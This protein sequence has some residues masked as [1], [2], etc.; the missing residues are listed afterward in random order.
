M[1]K[2]LPPPRCRLGI[3]PGLEL[4][5]GLG[6]G[7]ALG[8]G[9]GLG[10]SLP[11]AALQEACRIGA[12]VAGAAGATPRLEPSEIA[13]LLPRDAAADGCLVVPPDLMLGR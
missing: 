10:L 3:R 12:Y 7:L 6:L 9:L 11:A 4:G 5:L 2:P 8:L 13:A 1:A